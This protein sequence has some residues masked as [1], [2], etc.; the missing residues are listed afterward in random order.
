MRLVPSCKE[1]NSTMEEAYCSSCGG[2][3]EGY[4]TDSHCSTCGGSGVTGEYYCY[5]CEEE[6]E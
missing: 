5:W 1:C 4:T 3:G 2:C 6:E